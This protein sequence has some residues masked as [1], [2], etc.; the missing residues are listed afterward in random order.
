MILSIQW[1]LL[2][3]PGCGCVSKPPGAGTLGLLKGDLIAVSKEA[4][5]GWVSWLVSNERFP[6]T[7]G[8]N[9]KFAPETRPEAVCPKKETMKVWKRNPFSGAMSC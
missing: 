1:F 7:G 6:V 4:E 8:K 9:S 5:R 3:A 2:L